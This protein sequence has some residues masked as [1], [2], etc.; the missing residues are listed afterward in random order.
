MVLAVDCKLQYLLMSRKLLRIVSYTVEFI[1][2]I[3]K[4]Q[5][6]QIGTYRN[7]TVEILFV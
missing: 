5:L 3:D 7:R 1:L 6:I 2:I 4:I